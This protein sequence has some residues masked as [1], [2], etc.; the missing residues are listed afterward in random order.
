MSGR[1]EGE[2]EA[3]TGPVNSEVFPHS[4]HAVLIAKTKVDINVD[5]T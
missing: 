2:S 4:P 3:E 1:K 5:K